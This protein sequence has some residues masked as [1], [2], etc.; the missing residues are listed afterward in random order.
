M[1]LIGFPSAIMPSS[2][3][4]ARVRPP[5]AT[6]G[7]T[8]AWTIAGSSAVPPVA[9]ARIASASWV[10]WATWSFSRYPYP[11]EP[12][13]SSETAYSGSSYWDSTTT[14][15][16]GCRLRTS[17]A[18]SMPSRWNDGGMRMSVTST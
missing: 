8:S 13:A 18:A 10:P 17:L 6:T 14:P 4:S 5:G 7:W 12:S 16:P 9:T 15:V 2:S 3:S 1:A 11:A